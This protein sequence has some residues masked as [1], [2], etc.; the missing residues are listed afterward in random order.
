MQA[1]AVAA[2]VFRVA[3]ESLDIKRRINNISDKLLLHLTLFSTQ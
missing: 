1:A 3:S 2:A